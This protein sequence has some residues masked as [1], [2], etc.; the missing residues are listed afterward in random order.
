MNIQYLSNENGLV[1]AVQLPIEEW[2]KIKSI[3]PNVDSV[4][5][6]LPEWHKEILDSRLQAIEDN[7]ERVKPISELM[8]ELDK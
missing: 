1:T 3:Y 2:E 7:P 6:S 4:D 8:S 5:F